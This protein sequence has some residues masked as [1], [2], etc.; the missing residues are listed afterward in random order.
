MSLRRA[1]S[2][3][4]GHPKPN[5]N[6]CDKKCSPILDGRPDVLVHPP[7]YECVMD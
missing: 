2:Q 1:P 5:N 3:R 6:L 4:G 7:F